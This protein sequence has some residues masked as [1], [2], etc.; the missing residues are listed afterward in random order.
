[1]SNK[2]VKLIVLVGVLFVSFSSILSKIAT[3][4]PLIIATYRLGFSTLIMLP[5]FLRQERDIASKMTPRLWLLCIASGI[6]LALHFSTWLTS[7]K[8]T[9]I[10]SSTVLVNTHPIFILL[11]TFFITKENVSK[12]AVISIII[13]LIG[14]IVITLSDA[15]VEGHNL[16]GDFFAIA[17]GFFVA[18]YMLIGRKVRQHISVTAYTFIVYACCTLTLLLFDGIAKAPLLGYPKSD[19]LIF[20]SLAV[21][22]TLMGHSV[23][24]WALAYLNPTFVSTSILGEPVFATLLAFALLKEQPALLQLVGGGLILLGISLHIQAENTGAS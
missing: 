6:F 21:F 5:I 13:A 8:M 7:V 23:F 4:P 16:T 11:G 2:T 3:A 10:A 9:S 14:S 12:K 24:N 20:L 18:G 22:C 19:Y 15:G 1:M 17:G